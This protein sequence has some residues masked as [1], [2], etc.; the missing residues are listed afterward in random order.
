M[1][2]VNVR[3]LKILKEIQSIG[4]E[5]RYLCRSSDWDSF[6][7][8]ANMFLMK[9][10][11]YCLLFQMRVV[12]NSQM[13]IHDMENEKDRFVAQKHAKQ[14]CEE[15]EEYLNSSIELGRLMKFEDYRCIDWIKRLT[16]LLVDANRILDEEELVADESSITG[17]E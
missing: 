13:L 15:L 1:A 4:E 17:D 9:E 2:L 11:I 16:N 7:D 3:F 14:Y 12:L 6:M 5:A 8:G 10:K